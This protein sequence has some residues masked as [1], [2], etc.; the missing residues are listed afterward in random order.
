[1]KTTLTERQ[2][3]RSTT[4]RRRKEKREPVVVLMDVIVPMVEAAVTW[5]TLPLRFRNNY[6]SGFSGGA[7][8]APARR[9]LRKFLGDMH[10]AL[11][12]PRKK[13]T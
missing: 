9:V 13:K 6:L 3:K 7:I 5:A 8:N 10:Q 4:P 12:T 2:L 11:S 1:M